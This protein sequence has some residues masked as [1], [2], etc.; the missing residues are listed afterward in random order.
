MINIVDSKKLSIIAPNTNKA[1]KEVLKDISPKELQSISSGKDLK[2]IMDSI[3]KQSS[4]DNSNDKTLLGLVKNNP[5]LKNLGDVST[6]IKDLL[7]TIKSDKNPLPIEKVLKNILVDIKDVKDTQLKQKFENSGVFLESRI[8]DIKSPQQE[9]KSI[10]VSL[11][12]V[13]NKSEFSSSKIILNDVKTI[14]NNHLAKELQSAQKTVADI[15]QHKELILPKDISLVAYN[16]KKIVAELKSAQNMIQTIYK[17]EFEELIRKLE[18]LTSPKLLNVQDFKYPQVKEILEQVSQQVS[19][20][21][22]IESKGI[23]DALQKIFTSLKSIEQNVTTP[24]LILEN[25]ISKD[26]PKEIKNLSQLVK[27]IV[28]KADPIFSKTTLAIVD[29]LEVLSSTKG[30]NPQQNV[31]ELFSTDFKS[32]LLKAT[33]E[34]KNS[35]HPNKTE[36]LNH[37]DKLSLQIDNLQLVSHLSNA[38]SLYLPFSWDAMQEGKIEMKKG[39][40]NRF[41]CDIDLK[42]KEYGE[43]KFKLILYEKNQLNLHIYTTSKEFQNIIKENL[44]SLRSAIIDV[45]VTPREI[46]IFEPKETNATSAYNDYSGDLASGF[47]A[48]V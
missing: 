27:D 21:V 6:T 35:N 23:M 32:V 17:P 36:L 9:L 30:L 24:K 38:S 28:I 37:I 1:L 12:K 16:V 47:E 20:S 5:T 14:L 15:P 33:E 25:F 40:N 45:N 2:S 44:Q 18:H 31:K 43:L 22:S 7:N 41:Y 46:R 13:L 19:K 48:K 29:K 39:D 26:I 10:L 34:I 3:L 11:E 42:L 8:K 4:I